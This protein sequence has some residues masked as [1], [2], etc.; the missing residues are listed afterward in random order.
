MED[1]WV[2]VGRVWNGVGDRMDVLFAMLKP[3]V[4]LCFIPG[5]ILY[6]MNQEPKP[7]WFSLLGPF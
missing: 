7:S 3:V 1:A 2:K 5:V 4:H 6:G